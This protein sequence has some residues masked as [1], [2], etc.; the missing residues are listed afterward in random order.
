MKRLL[1]YILFIIVLASTLVP[2]SFIDDCEEAEHTE[3]QAD[4]GASKSCSECSPFSFCSSVPGINHNPISNSIEAPTKGITP[5]YSEYHSSDY[6]AYYPSL[7]Q[8]PR[9]A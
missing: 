9:M 3:Q 5:Q 1:T 2:C 6:E 7:F 8:P 4:A